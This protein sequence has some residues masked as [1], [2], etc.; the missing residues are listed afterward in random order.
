MCDADLGGGTLSHEWWALLRAG[1]H[2]DEQPG[3]RAALRRERAHHHEGLPVR[4]A[5]REAGPQRQ[6]GGKPL[7]P[8]MLPLSHAESLCRPKQGQGMPPVCV[9]CAGRPHSDSWEA[10]PD[11]HVHAAAPPCTFQIDLTERHAKV[12]YLQ[13]CTW[14]AHPGLVCGR[15]RAACIWTPVMGAAINLKQL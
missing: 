11:V 7:P 1:E 6:A 14:R 10:A 3:E 8:W 4:H 13:C 5:R 12:A 2:A 9:P 15:R